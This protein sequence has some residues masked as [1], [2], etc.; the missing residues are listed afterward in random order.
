MRK[1]FRGASGLFLGVALCDLL[2]TY[3][4]NLKRLTDMKESLNLLVPD[5]LCQVVQLFDAN[6][7]WGPF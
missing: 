7:L 3:Y 4:G 6:T 5:V 2:I 1:G